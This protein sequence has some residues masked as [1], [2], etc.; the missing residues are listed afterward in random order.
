MYEQHYGLNEKPFE[1]TPDARYF[2][3]SPEHEE[4][5]A[6]L[7]YA[8]S[9][10]KGFVLLTGEVGAGKTL[11][12]RVLLSRLP[13]GANTALVTNTH[14]SPKQLVRTLCQEYELPA[15]GAR[16][17]CDLLETFN[18]FLLEQLAS[19]R[20]V[21]SIVD[22]GQNLSRESLEEIRMLCNL[23]TEREKLLQIILMGQPELRKRIFMPDLEQLRQ[24]IAV[25]FHLR[26]LAAL[27]VAAYIN[28]RVT[29]A[30]RNGDSPLF[31][32]TAVRVVAQ[33]S[34]GVPRLINAIC[35]CS[36]VLGFAR[37]SA[38]ID[39]VIVQ[40]AIRQHLPME[41]RPVHQWA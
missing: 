39:D 7:V 37:R 41:A 15:T 5:L 26:P 21:V 28:H 8:V 34:R 36:L 30:G 19:D 27:D 29:V 24:R 11:L 20:L 9:E 25:S 35:D 12:S 18:K 2:Y 38:T 6:S 3:A 33:Y 40:T 16:D 1:N 10:R 32:E 14:L 17:K 4:A 13:P 31:T 23:E 22:E